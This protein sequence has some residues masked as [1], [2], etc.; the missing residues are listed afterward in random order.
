MT[1]AGTGAGVG[2]AGSVE[3]DFIICLITFETL[4]LDEIKKKHFNFFFEW[5]DDGDAHIDGI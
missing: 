2:T 1:E 3:F 4:S 5:F